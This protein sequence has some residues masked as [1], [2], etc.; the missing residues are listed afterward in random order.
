MPRPSDGLDAKHKA[1]E[2]ILGRGHPSIAS[3]Q[4][5]TTTAR[6]ADA[7]ALH[8]LADL[9]VRYDANTN[10]PVIDVTINGQTVALGLQLE[11]P[12]SALTTT[13]V[14]RLAL[15]AHPGAG[16]QPLSPSVSFAAQQIP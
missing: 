13:T 7:C 2:H 5:S 16:P 10:K 8:L 3:I 1:M 9:P 15:P 11:S 4:A 14:G 12:V 6:A